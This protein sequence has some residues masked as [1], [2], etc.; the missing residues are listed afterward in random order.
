M[1]DIMENELA[2]TAMQIILNAGDA[3]TDTT[4]ALAA[5]KQWNFTEA[6]AKLQQAKEA[7]RLAHISQ[8]EIIQ[9]ETR[10]KEYTPSLLFIH[11]QDTLMTINSEVL[12]AEQL[13]DLFEAVYKRIGE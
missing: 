12:L 11:A 5:V 7:I 10:G 4:S 9:N 2:E 8:T 3:R 6:R 1:E 13:I